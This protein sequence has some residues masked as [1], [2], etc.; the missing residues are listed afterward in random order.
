MPTVKQ[1]S[2]KRIII[3]LTKLTLLLVVIMILLSGGFLLWQHYYPV[4]TH[5]AWSYQVLHQNIAKPSALIID[6]QDNLIVAN[7]LNNQKGSIISIDNS[8]K[9]TTL[10][11][12]LDKPD[13]LVKLGDGYVFS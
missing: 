4:T 10:F 12:Q 5:K 6:K 3:H 13:G 2:A 8:G 7:E 11:T 9:V 1:P